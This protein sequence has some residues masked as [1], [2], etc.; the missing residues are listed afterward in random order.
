MSFQC[1]SHDFLSFTSFLPIVANSFATLGSSST[2]IIAVINDT[3][4]NPR[5]QRL[6]SPVS[7]SIFQPDTKI[8]N[9]QKPASTFG[10][11]N[12]SQS[13]PLYRIAS[14]PTQVCNSHGVDFEIAVAFSL[15]TKRPSTGELLPNKTFLLFY[16]AS[17]STYLFMYCPIWNHV[18]SP[19][20]L[21]SFCV[22]AFQRTGIPFS[23]RDATDTPVKGLT[24][25]PTIT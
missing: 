11:F 1:S 19:T 21:R 9:L 7:W 14:K 22:V 10:T 13:L 5:G 12:V 20:M 24:P 23:P 17:F 4:Q 2:G 18:L 25:S 15:V 3:A 8:F 16:H 6:S